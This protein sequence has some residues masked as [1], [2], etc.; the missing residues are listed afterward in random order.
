MNTVHCICDNNCLFAVKKQYYC[1]FT[2]HILKQE[3][4]KCIRFE[5]VSSGDVY[6]AYEC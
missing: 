1:S 4:Y 6:I 3:N 5:M 2:Y